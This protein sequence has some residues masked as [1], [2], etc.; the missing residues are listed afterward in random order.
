MHLTVLYPSLHQT[1]CR[2]PIRA[3]VRRTPKNAIVW[4]DLLCA[5]IGVVA[6]IYAYAAA[7]MVVRS[8]AL[9]C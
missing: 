6:R 8:V 9:T 1:G 4:D 3:H 5:G 2:T 7:Q